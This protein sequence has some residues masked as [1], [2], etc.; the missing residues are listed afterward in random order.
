MNRMDGYENH[1]FGIGVHAN[2]H[3]H[4]HESYPGKYNIL[5]GYFIEEFNEKNV[6][7]ANTF[8][9]VG[10]AAPKYPKRPE[11]RIGTWDKEDKDGK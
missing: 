3:T 8:P 2:K 6:C 4:T 1:V 7:F 9:P 5:S 10:V 11:E